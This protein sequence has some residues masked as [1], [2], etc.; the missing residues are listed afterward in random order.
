MFEKTVF[1]IRLLTG[2]ISFKKLFNY[3][4]QILGL[5]VIVAS[6]FLKLQ[7]RVKKT[8]FYKIVSQTWYS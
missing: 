8:K 1:Y 6:L 7:F 5:A 2:E 3:F 4:L